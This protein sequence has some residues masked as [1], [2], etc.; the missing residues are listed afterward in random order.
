M[1]EFRL[2][3]SLENTLRAL[4]VTAKATIGRCDVASATLVQEG[5]VV[6]RGWTDRIAR[7]LD[8]AQSKAG[9][10][11]AVDA[12]HLLRAV[13]VPSVGDREGC[14]LF[15]EVA[16]A[17]GIRSALSFPLV[18]RG[19]AIGGVNLYSRDLHGFEMCEPQVEDFAARAAATLLLSATLKGT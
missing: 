4:A 2:G 18:R 11:P 1:S 14:D 8:S 19:R 6:G 7:D 16:L 12:L 10:G 13:N 5:E 17:N 15:R 9:E 3:P